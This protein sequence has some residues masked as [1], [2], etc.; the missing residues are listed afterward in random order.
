MVY[1]LVAGMDEQN[2]WKVTQLN[3]VSTSPEDLCDLGTEALF[4][5]T[6]EHTNISLSISP[7]ACSDF[8]A[9]GNTQVEIYMGF[10]REL[11]T[12]VV[13]AFKAGSLFISEC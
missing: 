13:E 1:H 6:P 7:T 2:Y 9:V 5:D 3:P 4:I 10:S 11:P 12:E 8:K